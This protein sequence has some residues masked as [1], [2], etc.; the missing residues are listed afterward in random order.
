M[1]VITLKKAIGSN[2]SVSQWWSS[3]PW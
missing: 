3:E 2:V 1:K